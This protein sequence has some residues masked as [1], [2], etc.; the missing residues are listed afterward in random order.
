MPSNISITIIT[1]LNCLMTKTETYWNN[2]KQPYFF[3]NGHYNI[4]V[5]P[6]LVQ[7]ERDRFPLIIIDFSAKKTWFLSNTF[8]QE[9]LIYQGK[10]A[11]ESNRSVCVYIYVCVYKCQVYFGIP[12]LP[13]GQEVLQEEWLAGTGMRKEI[14]SQWVIT[15]YIYIIIHIYI[16]V[17]V[18]LPINK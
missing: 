7:K 14:A 8:E 1:T 2:M 6:H 18:I 4:F 16:Y 3:D 15:T 13:T 11:P 9:T 12:C 17:C 10:G 5:A